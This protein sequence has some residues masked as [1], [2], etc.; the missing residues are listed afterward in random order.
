MKGR[1]KKYI[2]IV[3]AAVLMMAIVNSVRSG[4]KDTNSSTATGGPGGIYM[5][6]SKTRNSTNTVEQAYCQIGRNNGSGVTYAICGVSDVNRVRTSC[7]TTNLDLVRLI[8]DATDTAYIDVGF[9]ISTGVCTS[10][11]IRESSMTP[12]KRHN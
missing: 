6:L 11:S 8:A 7:T 10:V 12:D 1:S 4:A 2:L 3:S 5:S 9:N